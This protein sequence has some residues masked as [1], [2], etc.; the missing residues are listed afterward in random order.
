MNHVCAVE[1]IVQIVA[2][3]KVAPRV[4][5]PYTGARRTSIMQLTP[6]KAQRTMMIEFALTWLI[7]AAIGLIILGDD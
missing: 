7:G 2:P 1:P 4:D 5:V 3:P 6:N